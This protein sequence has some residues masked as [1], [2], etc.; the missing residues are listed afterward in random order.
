[1]GIRK[2]MKPGQLASLKAALIKPSWVFTLVMGVMATL[3]L[4]QPA[5]AGSPLYMNSDNT[6]LTWDTT[7]TIKY[8]VDPEG[9]GIL[10]YAQSLVLIQEAMAVWESVVGTGIEFEYLGPTDE[11]ITIDNW[12]EIAANHIF[13]E[14]YQ[15]TSALTTDSQR[16]HYLVI[17]FDNTGEIMEAKGSP[18]AAGIQSHTG[19]LGT[20]E[21]P[22][23]FISGHVF[24]NGLYYNN[25]DS[26]I[27]DLE[28]IDLM[29]I[30]VHELGHVLGL[31]H[32]VFHYQ[33]YRE[34]LDGTLNPNYARFLPTMFPRFIKGSGS[35]LISLHPDDIAT[36][37]W[38]YG[39]PDYHTISG[40]VL[41]A[42]GEPQFAAL[43]TARNTE[44]ALCH[45]YAQA[46]G[47]TCSD[48][49][50]SA[51]GTGA[52]YFNAK[53]CLDKTAQ[54][55]YIIPVL[56]GGSYTVDVSEIPSFLKSSISKFGSVIPELAGDAEFFNKN[57]APTESSYD[58]DEILIDGED[59]GPVDIMLSSTV[60]S[61]NQLDRITDTY[62]E[63][64]SFFIVL[65]D[66]PDCPLT[67]DFDIES[68]VYNTPTSSFVTTHTSTNTT[69]AGCSLNTGH[70]SGV[71]GPGPASW[72][73]ILGL[74]GFL[75]PRR[76][77]PT[78][79]L[80]FRP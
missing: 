3:L 9:L 30:I 39:A 13:A 32:N 19:V 1:M 80:T 17:G 38:M 48:M 10:T 74:L 6:P 53:N 45:A 65:D 35:H 11:A 4:L 15:T 24:I 79:L 55:A 40:E 58:Y 14:G 25:N 47:A 7:Q 56:R 26:D 67:N 16:E 72:F 69:P 18:G 57:D 64:D 20:Y 34:I 70:G 21:D 33:M 68:I 59:V 41:N 27:P 8:K 66:E 50:T 31:D 29:A 44:S 75:L 43:V 73:V 60:A 42:N 22:Q 49:N 46:T 28:L 61:S 78:S 77:P 37:K 5:L 63:Q 51:T 52:A 2:F 12:E 71:R 62:F 23:Y 76:S 54:G 36:L